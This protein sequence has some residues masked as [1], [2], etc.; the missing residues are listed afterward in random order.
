MSKVKLEENKQKKLNIFSKIIY[1]VAKIVKIATIIGAISMIITAIVIPIISSKIKYE[2]NA[3]NIKESNFK[4][5]RQDE[6]IKII[7]NNVVLF[8][9]DIGDS[10]LLDQIHNEISTIGLKNIVIFLE[11]AVIS[12]TIILVLLYFVF[13]YVE[14]IFRNIHDNDSPFTKEN[15]EY[16]RNVAYFLIAL[17]IVPIITDLIANMFVNGK[18]N[19]NINFGDIVY[20]LIVYSMSYI[21][22]YG[23]KLEESKNEI[24][25]IPKK[26]KVIK[27]KKETKPKTTK[28]AKSVK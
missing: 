13:N 9:E 11:I 21:F 7:Q 16:I 6:E 10:D 22:E 12:L 14:K 15:A 23:Y 17:F 8:S 1:I 28:V 3:L 5:I 20:I 25:D 26:E 27:E 19:I 4:I 2:N 24:L 18:L